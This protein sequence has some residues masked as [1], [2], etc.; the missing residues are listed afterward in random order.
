MKFKTFWALLL[1]L[2]LVAAACSDDTDPVEDVADDTPS[3]TADD[4]PATTTAVTTPTSTTSTTVAEKSEVTEARIGLQLEPPTLDLTA[5]PAAAIPQVLLYNVYETLV[6]LQADGS[7]TGLLAESWEVSDDALTYTFSLRDGVSFHNGDPLTAEDVV[8]SIEN[9][10]REEEVENDEGELVV[11]TVHPFASTFAPIDTVTAVDDSTVEITLTQPSANLLFFMTQGQ[12]VILNQNA[13][14]DIANNA[15]GTGPFEFEEWEVGDHI[16][17]I[18]ND[19]YWGEPALLETID[20]QY[21]ADPNALNNAM[22]SDQLDLVAGVSAPEL[23]EVFEAD[24]RFE[25]LTG[26]TYGEVTL[27]LNGRR[28]PFDDVLVRQ[29][30]SHAIDRQ[31][32]VDLAYAGYG[33][34]IGSFSTPLDP[35]FKDLTGVY[36]YDPARAE[37]LLTEA[38]ATGATIEMVLPPPS[39]A[40][41]GGEIIA[42]QL[43]QVGL[44]VNITNVEWGV[45]LEDV[46]SNND[47]DMSIVAHVEPLDLAQY[48]NP[49]Y[50]WGNDSPDVAPILAQA[51]A[52]ADPDVRNELYGQVLD[53]ITAQAAD[54][55]LF[56]IP[57]LSVLR[58][59]TTGYKVDLP[60]SLDVTQM[61]I[62]P[63]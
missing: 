17:I 52:E 54:Q 39:Y 30:V 35:W 47:F 48:G 43:E 51:D 53:E 34:P 20:F 41:R 33:T 29:A 46:F 59:G 28:A 6:R 15:I 25:V 13:I 36:P 55:W 23:L 14:D 60:G 27:S 9:V 50:Y 58:E 18:S 37:E 32:V 4:A 56:V 3:T 44:D 24:E 26:L 40:S 19:D 5:S 8:F 63:R 62:N 57:Q 49:D 2:S 16:T 31:A 11:Q 45:W 42:S 7:I 22:L 10:L 12:G 21:I 38:G 1:T 61:A